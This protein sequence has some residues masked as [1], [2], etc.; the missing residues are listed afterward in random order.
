MITVL[1]FSVCVFIYSQ[2]AKNP[3]KVPRKVCVFTIS[4]ITE[5]TKQEKFLPIFRDSIK[6]NLVL[7]LK[8]A[9]FSIV[10]ESKWRDKQKELGIAEND[11]FE[12]PEAMRLAKGAD[13]DVAVSGFLLLTKNKILF[14]I[15]CYDVQAKRL[16]ATV[17]KSGK[18][19]LSV[20]SLINEAIAEI[21][22]KI[23]Q[24]LD[25][26]TVKEGEIEK[27]VTVFKDIT[28]KEIKSMGETINVTLTSPDEG[29]EVYLA[30]RAMGKI[31]EGKIVFE[32]STNSSL[33]V[34][35]S[36][37]G[38]Y[39]S[40]REIPVSDADTSVTFD[41]LYKTSS[42][43]E[44][45]FNYGLFQFFGFGAGMRYYPV[46]PWFD[47]TDWTFVNLNNYLY[48]QLDYTGNVTP[49]IHDDINLTFNQYALLGPDSLFRFGFY[50]GTGIILTF[51]TVPNM[52]VYSDFYLDLF[53]A[54]IELNFLDYRIFLRGSLRMY[55][56]FFDIIKNDLLG[57]G[58]ND[59]PVQ[60]IGVVLKW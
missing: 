47:L 2:D 45:E 11:L 42:M 20:S 16:A 34:R 7:E 24:A 33:L 53:G 13:A 25:I 48:L 54:W 12:G 15:K 4:D 59:G 35:L 1:L 37:P 36:K 32:A 29:A 46:T 23:T 22:P 51:F 28:L 5:D 44:P 17:I 43:F 49:V 18:Q 10:E 6:E 26:Y 41:P 58:F 39:D 3:E 55:V 57:E 50:M 56:G 52:P 30:D 40:A 19:G 21:I 27:E 31:T 14:G 38:F 8:V 9:G 60:S